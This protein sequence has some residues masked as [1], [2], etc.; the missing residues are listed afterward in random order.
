M[1]GATGDGARQLSLHGVGVLIA[2]CLV[3]GRLVWV[4]RVGVFRVECC[5]L[6]PDD[7]AFN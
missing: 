1:R 4:F 6:A 3:T 2:N 5:S 7:G